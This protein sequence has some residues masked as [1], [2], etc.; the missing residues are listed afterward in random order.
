[1]KPYVVINVAVSAD[2][3]MDTFE[4]KGS[5]ISSVEDKA[6]VQCLRAEADA[7]MVG[8]H[9][10]LSESPKLTVKTPELRAE[11]VAK[12]LPENPMKVGV[13]SK[14]DLRPDG[15]FITAGPARRVIFTTAQTPQEQINVLSNLGVE[16]YVHSEKQVD[17]EKALETLHQLG[18]RKLMV[19]GGGTLNFELLRQGFVD[20]LSM[21]IAPKIFGGQSAPT[22]ADGNGLVESA[23]KTLKLVDV[24]VLDETGGVLINYRLK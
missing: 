10:L 1:M 15:D 6:R 13:V 18:V 21:Y 2:G 23:V 8:G 5:S 19:E 14:A 3:K 4:R 11:R 20:E 12:G 22:L 9:T 16:V 7:I 17:L 24:R